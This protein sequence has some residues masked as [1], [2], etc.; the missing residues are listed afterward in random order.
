MNTQ[1][2][3]PAYTIPEQDSDLWQTGRVFLDK[4][5]KANAAHE[6]RFNN[7]RLARRSYVCLMCKKAI[8]VGEVLAPF[9]R[10]CGPTH[11]R[12]LGEW[13][14]PARDDLLART[15]HQTEPY[16]A[17]HTT[18]RGLDVGADFCG[19][20]SRKYG[21]RNSDYDGSG[22]SRAYEMKLTRVLT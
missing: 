12:C 11:L 15:S 9:A 16:A 3:L 17:H 2:K 10:S 5:A 7:A 1:P 19:S 4:T 6:K 18:F 21:L 20:R 13:P 22:M 8:A 14:A